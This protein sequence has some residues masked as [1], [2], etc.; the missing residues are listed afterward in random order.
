LWSS[1]WR[2]AVAH[3]SAVQ[4]AAGRHDPHGHDD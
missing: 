1:V 3:G 2:G 4:L